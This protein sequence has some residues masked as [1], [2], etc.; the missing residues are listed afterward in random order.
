MQDLES[1]PEVRALQQRCCSWWGHYRIDVVVLGTADL[2]PFEPISLVKSFA[3]GGCTWSCS[4]TNTAELCLKV[5]AIFANNIREGNGRENLS[6][7]WVN[8]FLHWIVSFVQVLICS[9]DSEANGQL[10]SSLI[11]NL[12]RFRNPS[13]PC[14]KLFLF[15]F[16]SKWWVYHGPKN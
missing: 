5:N 4:L 1:V 13:G 11:L 16:Q 8:L 3:S 9:F 14:T 6:V 10:F 15:S 7:Q 2:I 12:F